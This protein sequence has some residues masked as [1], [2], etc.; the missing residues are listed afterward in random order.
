M[1]FLEPVLDGP[2]RRRLAQG[3]PSEAVSQDETD[4]VEHLQDRVVG[5]EQLLRRRPAA[6]SERVAVVVAVDE[7]ELAQKPRRLLALSRV[8]ARST[9]PR[10]TFP[11]SIRTSLT[12]RSGSGSSSK[13]STLIDLSGRASE[14]LL[15]GLRVAASVARCR[16]S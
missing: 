2:Q 6:R 1:E 12:A 13:L 10:G 14:S 16:T 7:R 3:R 9:P 8:G 15:A 11:T 5:V 4:A